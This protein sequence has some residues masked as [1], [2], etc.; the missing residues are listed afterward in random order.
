MRRIIAF[1]LCFCLTLLSI[2]GAAWADDRAKEEFTRNYIYLLDHSL[3][4]QNSLL[5]NLINNTVNMSVRAKLT[6]G[7]VELA[8]VTTVSNVDGEANVDL[9]FN[10]KEKKASLKFD[11]DIASYDLK[12][13]VYVTEDGV[14]VTREAVEAFRKMGIDALGELDEFNELPSYIVFQE[15]VNTKELEE[16]D[17][18]LEQQDKLISDKDEEMKTFIK[19]LINVIPASCFR[20]SGKY[21]VLDLD[22]SVFSSAVL[23]NNLKENSEKLVDAFL[24][25]MEKPEDVSDEEY[26]L[27]KEQMKFEIVNAIDSVSISDVQDFMAQLNDEKPIS[28][29]KFQ[30]KT[31]RTEVV[32]D[33]DL[34][35]KFEEISYVLKGESKAELTAGALKGYANLDFKLDSPDITIDLNMVEDEKM[36]DK[37]I[38]AELTVKG[39]MDIDDNIIG[40]NVKMDLDMDFT[41]NA[42]IVIPNLNEENSLVIDN[43][44]KVSPAESGAVYPFLEGIEN[45][46]NIRVFVYGEE[47]D[48]PDA[49][50]IIREGRT[51]LPLRALADVLDCEIAWQPPDKVI[52]KDKYGESEDMLLII[53]SREYQMGDEVEVMDVAP[54]IIDNRTYVPVRFIAENFGFTV[55]WHKDTRSVILD[56]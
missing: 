19:E 15:D 24:A 35:G 14:I 9:A 18:V 47:V 38:Q 37:E 50:P 43:R 40:G 1:V 5:K 36:N 55:D 16:L 34:S 41:D 27:L 7:S 12:G 39:D 6:D 56:W 48:F 23:L 17:E 4:M 44:I 8:D 11:G 52:L 42:T 31:S 20:Y 10:L 49:K 46:G 13:K 21:A 28:I 3:K 45:N 54:V 22:M 26:E 33:I 32:A 53:G 25:L 29:N 51:L 2:P 30:I